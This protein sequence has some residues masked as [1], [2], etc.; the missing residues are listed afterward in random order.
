MSTLESWV[1]I[2]PYAAPIVDENEESTISQTILS[3]PSQPDVN[4]SSAQVTSD[5]KDSGPAKVPSGSSITGNLTHAVLSAALNVPSSATPSDPR[6]TASRLLSTRDSLSIP[7]TTVNFR[8]FVSK[9]GA[10]FWLQDRIEEIIFWRKGWKVT[11]AWIVG[12]SFICENYVQLVVLYETE[13]LQAI[14]PD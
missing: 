12:Y 1:E 13:Q 10:V 11:T 9:T 6:K 7:I 5:A 8:R 4:P 3:P 14:I 2:P